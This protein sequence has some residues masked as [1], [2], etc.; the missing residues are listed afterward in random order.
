MRPIVFVSSIV[1][2]DRTSL[3]ANNIAKQRAPG[4]VTVLFHDSALS[5]PR[6]RAPTLECCLCDD[7]AN[8]STP[9][10]RPPESDV[11]AVP[12]SL[13][14]AGRLTHTYDKCVNGIV[15]MVLCPRSLDSHKLPCSLN[16]LLR[17]R[18][19]QPL[20]DMPQISAAFLG[21]VIADP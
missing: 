3:C 5:F 1:S 9:V 8:A 13:E 11:V 6:S 18:N 12:T 15:I 7:A 2:P 4:V 14:P 16:R 20:Y 21:V 10:R 17:P 19:A